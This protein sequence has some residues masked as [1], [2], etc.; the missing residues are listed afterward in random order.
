MSRLVPAGSIILTPVDARI[1]YQAAQLGELR[2]RYRIGDTRT[3][4]LL[5]EISQAA[6]A[7]DAA[8]AIAADGILPRQS[9]AK[10][11]RGLWTVQEIAR[12]AHL[13]ERTVRLDCKTGELPATKQG[14][15]WAITADEA[16][17]YIERRRRR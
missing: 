5:T 7:V 1:L 2:S 8:A 14:N 12:A 3:Y 4:E 9:A 10:E 6:F 15:T 16:Q 13:A 17:T 11:E